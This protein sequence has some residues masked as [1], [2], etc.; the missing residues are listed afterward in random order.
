MTSEF[1]SSTK[2]RILLFF[3]SKQALGL[4]GNDGSFQYI[5][6]NYPVQKNS[7]F[8]AAFAIRIITLSYLVKMQNG[9]F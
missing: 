4:L 5:Y 1:L 2:I 3:K 8:S 6:P 9:T 7:R